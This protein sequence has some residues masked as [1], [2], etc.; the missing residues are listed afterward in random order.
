MTVDDLDPQVTP[1]EGE[2]AGQNQ[3]SPPQSQQ[4]PQADPVAQKLNELEAHN[5]ELQD[6]LTRQGRELANMRRQP[7]TQT[8]AEER[9]AFFDDPDGVLEAFKRDIVNT[10]EQHRQTDMMLRNFA[11]EKGIPMRRLQSLNDRLSSAM[12]NPDDYLELLYEIH[13][14]QDAATQ[15]QKAVSAATDTVKQQ[16]RAVTAEGGQPAP[17]EP[18]EIPIEEFRKWP[19]EKRA[20]YLARRFGVQD[21]GI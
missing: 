1:E 18:A 3:D 19:K 11:E 17:G 20:E 13:A 14:A 2:D 9:K 7:Q 8:P 10:L 6:R 21:F 12:N 16:A 15:V 5:K 4:A